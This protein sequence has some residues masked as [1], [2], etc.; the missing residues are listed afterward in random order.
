MGYRW[1][2]RPRDTCRVGESRCPAQ[3]PS[4]VWRLREAPAP[5]TPHGQRKVRQETGPWEGP[6]SM[7]SS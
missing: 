3:G 5:P 2:L 6:A 7:A 1:G 4:G